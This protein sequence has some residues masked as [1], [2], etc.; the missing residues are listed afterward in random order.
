MGQG[1][2]KQKYTLC[3]ITFSSLK[4][5]RHFFAAGH[6]KGAVDRV[7]RSGKRVENRGIMLKKSTSLPNDVKSFAECANH[8]CNGVEV[9]YC[10]KEDTERDIAAFEEGV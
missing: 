2:F 1:R 3:N 7:R 4:V 10:L 8:I 5:N 9:I 6:D